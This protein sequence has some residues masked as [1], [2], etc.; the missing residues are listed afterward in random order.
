MTL[1][2]TRLLVYVCHKP[3]NPVTIGVATM[4][5]TTMTRSLSRADGWPPARMT[6]LNTT[7]MSS[8]LTR[9][10]AEVARMRNATSDTLPR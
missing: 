6:S 1:S 5:A 3:S 4:T 10:S 9:P 8:G 7:L 2:P